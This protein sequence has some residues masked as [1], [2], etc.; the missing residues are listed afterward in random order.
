[1]Y[2][3]T[4]LSPWHILCDFD[5]T[6]TL[7]DVTDG[8]LQRFAPAQWT[9]IEYAWQIGQIGS[10]ECLF[11]QIALVRATHHELDAYL[12]QVGVDPAFSFFVKRCQA[13][14]I[15]LEIISDGL[16]YV[17]RRIL[18]RHDLGHI[19]F[20]ANQLLF[21][22]YKRYAVGFPHADPHC[23]KAAG[24]CKC[25]VE[26][27]KPQQMLLLI[28]DGTSDCC[29]AGKVDFVLAKDRLLE[30]CQDHGLPHW[31]CPDFQHA[32]PMLEQLLNTKGLLPNRY[33]QRKC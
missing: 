26:Q 11:R 10:K 22:G 9:E 30:Y 23:T 29:L 7:E 6:I 31:P 33:Y 8:I 17:I 3:D 18:A 20:C 5:N 27:R 14:G 21:L 28:G 15:S 19:P 1:M 2:G 13:L 32:G 4:P 25:A 16:D 24:V 12:D